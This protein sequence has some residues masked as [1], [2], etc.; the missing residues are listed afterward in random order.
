MELIPTIQLSQDSQYEQSSDQVSRRQ[1]ILA[2]QEAYKNV[3]TEF[4]R[5]QLAKTKESDELPS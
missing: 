3:C 4:K 5:Q 1:A 2:A